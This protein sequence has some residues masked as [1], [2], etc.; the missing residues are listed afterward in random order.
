MYKKMYTQAKESLA[1]LHCRKGSFLWCLPERV[2]M[3]TDFVYGIQF[4]YV[5]VL[6]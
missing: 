2:I 6:K 1:E 5:E 3:L 4:Y